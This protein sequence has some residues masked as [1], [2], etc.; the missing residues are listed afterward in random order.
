MIL[1][2]IILATYVQVT[3]MNIKNND[4]Y[5]GELMSQIGQ[6]VSNNCSSLQN[7]MISIAYDSVVQKYL[8]EKDKFGRV[9]L[10]YDLDSNFMNMEHIKDGILDFIILGDNGVSYFYK[11]K[12][13]DIIKVLNSI[14][15]HPNQ[16]YTALKTLEYDGVTRRCF[17][18]ASDFYAMSNKVLGSKIGIAAIVIDC[19][20][21]GIESRRDIGDSPSK[22]YL[23]DRQ[24]IV[25]SGNDSSKLYSKLALPESME[26]GTIKINNERFIMNSQSISE[27]GGRI[28]SIVPENKLFGDTIRIRNMMIIIV[29]IGGIPLIVL[30]AVLIKNILQP[31]NKFMR[32]LASVKAGNL[33]GLRQRIGLE[34][35]AEIKIMS[36]EFNCLLDEIDSL[37]HRLLS[38]SSRMYELELQK[39]Q[40]EISQLKSQI[41]PHFLYNTL[42]SMKGVA[43]EENACKIFDMIDALGRIFSYSVKGADIVAVRDELDIVKSYVRIQQIRFEDRFEFAY[44]IQDEALDC[45]IPKMTLQPIVENAVFHGLES[46]L[47]KGWL[48]IEG[49]I[50]NNVG[51]RISIKDNGVGIDEGTLAAIKAKLSGSP[52]L[53]DSKKSENSNIGLMNVNSRIKLM[54]GADYGIEV[55][56]VLGRGSEVIIRI[57]FRNDYYV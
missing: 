44:E 18:V 15:E 1:F 52:V 50:C 19:S 17:V 12:R 3:K 48:R 22:F 4:E 14:P 51:L 7:I 11:G 30:F 35:Y 31:L 56:S 20:V 55:R 57:P 47:E 49:E 13:D 9:K 54:Y 26:N 23:V 37:T 25:Y 40:S 16:Y 41:N 45:S 6:S 36:H 21:L 10:S 8:T 2:A 32:Y 39:K 34:G 24:G 27:F 28:I 43:L 5:T 46:I 53:P 33:K 29:F 38:T 42:E